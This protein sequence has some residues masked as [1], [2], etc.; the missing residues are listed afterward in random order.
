M[1]NTIIIILILGISVLTLTACTDEVIKEEGIIE[2]Q[3]LSES[4]QGIEGATIKF[5]SEI[6]KTSIVETDSL[7]RFTK[8]GLE[9]KY[10]VTVAKNDYG[11]E[12]NNK[13]AYPGDDLIFIGAKI[14]KDITWNMTREEVFNIE[15]AEL[16]EDINDDLYQRYI[17]FMWAGRDKLT[18]R[19]SLNNRDFY[20][21]YFFS[22]DNTL[23][24]FSYAPYE[25]FNYLEGELTKRNEEYFEMKNFLI[26]NHVQEDASEIDGATK[27]EWRIRDNSISIKKI[28]ER[29]SEGGYL[30][31]YRI[32]IS[33][34]GEAEVILLH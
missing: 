1:K 20:L 34:E 6:G 17:D 27:S 33:G 28:R 26:N 15:T 18:Y 25:K 2:G 31:S 9:G 19:V 7:G 8:S 16:I 5:V 14:T 32:V 3:V 10:E 22:I 30:N 12:E 24:Y 13:V 29:R 23:S 4:N 11:F 21:T